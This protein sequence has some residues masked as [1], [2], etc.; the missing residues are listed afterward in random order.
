MSF[1]FTFPAILYFINFSM[2]EIRILHHLIRNQNLDQDDTSIILRKKLLIFYF[3]FCKNYTNKTI[4]IIMFFSMFLALKFL[5]YK[6]YFFISVLFTWTPQII[7]NFFTYNR[8]LMPLINVV[9]LSINK[10]VVS[11]NNKLYYLS[12]LNIL[13]SIFIFIKS[14][15]LF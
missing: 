14:L 11:V 7:S 5:F 3:S 2:F 13:I 15:V 4:D 12:L 1:Y 6:H 9:L 10:L 8:L